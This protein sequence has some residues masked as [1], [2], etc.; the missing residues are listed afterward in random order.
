MSKCCYQKGKNFCHKVN[1]LN[2]YI[3][4]VFSESLVVKESYTDKTFFPTKYD[5]RQLPQPGCT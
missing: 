5:M 4:K 2:V 3:E 1:L